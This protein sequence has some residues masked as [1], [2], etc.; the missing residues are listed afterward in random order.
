M[1]CKPG[2]AT[3]LS[4]NLMSILMA[5]SISLHSFT[6]ATQPNGEVLTPEVILRPIAF[7]SRHLIW[8]PVDD[9]LDWFAH[10]TTDVFS[11]LS[12]PLL[13]CHILGSHKRTLTSSPGAW[14]S[15]DGVTVSMYTVNPAL[16]NISGSDI[17]RIG[18]ICHEMGH[19]MGASDMYDTDGGKLCR[20]LVAVDLTL[21]S[22]PQ[23]RRCNSSFR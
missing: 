17:G 13:F 3:I 10:E 4:V 9:I 18:V 1:H 21:F 19:Y 16:W 7:V 15:R 11:Q 14:V 12:R 23:R 20:Q 5:T 8:S 22:T 6:Q 2:R